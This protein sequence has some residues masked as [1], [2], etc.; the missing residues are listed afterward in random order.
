M[1]AAGK[2]SRFA[3]IPLQY[4]NPEADLT[5]RPVRMPVDDQA[6]RICQ[7]KP[8]RMPQQPELTSPPLPATP[9]LQPGAEMASAAVAGDGL[10]ASE[11][12]SPQRIP[13]W[14]ERAEFALRKLLRMY[15][16]LLICYLPWSRVLPILQPMA[17]AFWDEN[18]LF[19]EFPNLAIYA[20]DGMVRGLISG[21]GLLNIW[22]AFHDVI[23]HGTDKQ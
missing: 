17:R 16:G 9:A 1:L 21:L 15:I 13:R 23:R 19:L 2:P 3:V 6:M 14:L 5:C 11:E 8:E 4:G 20:N 18:P 10:A 22:I 7:A 12:H